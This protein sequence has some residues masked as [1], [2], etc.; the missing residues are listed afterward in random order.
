M[1]SRIAVFLVVALAVVSGA[2]P[3]TA[4]ERA[5][6]QIAY[7]EL[8]QEAREVLAQIKR[9]ARFP[10]RQDGSEFGNRERRLPL[11][12]RGY[13]REYTV[14]TPGAKDRGARRIVAGSG[15]AGDVRT[16]GEYYYSDDHYKSFRRI[17]E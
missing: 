4:G 6:A 5:S 15:A 13:Y 11:K 1:F 8:P 7:A 12:E 17:K 16:S 3:V 10:Y 2:A 14:P 9:G